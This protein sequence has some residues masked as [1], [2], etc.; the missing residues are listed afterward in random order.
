MG[1]I[2]IN[3]KDSIDDD[4]YYD[5][6]DDVM[7]DEE[8][9]DIETEYYEDIEIPDDYSWSGFMETELSNQR[10]S[11]WN[12]NDIFDDSYQNS[13]SEEE[14]FLDPEELGFNILDVK[15]TSSEII[16]RFL[17]LQRPHMNKKM[18]ECM[19]I[20]DFLKIFINN[21][22]RVPE[23]VLYNQDEENQGFSIDESIF[24]ERDTSDIKLMKRSYN[25]IQVL[26][27]SNLST[28]VTEKAKVIGKELMNIF[29]PKSE[30]NFNHFKYIWNYL[31]D[32]TNGEIALLLTSEEYKE[33]PV[34]KMLRY[35]HEHAITSSLLSSI[36]LINSQTTLQMELFTKLQ[37][38]EFVETI[39]AML[40]MTDFP[41]T[42]TAASEFLIQ[43]IEEGSKTEDSDILLFAIQMD[44]SCLS[45]IIKHVSESTSVVQQDACTELLLAFLEK[46]IYTSDNMAS[47]SSSFVF[48]EKTPLKPLKQSIL[49]YLKYNIYELCFGLK[50]SKI[51]ENNL[52]E[53]EENN[54]NGKE[55]IK[56]KQFTAKKR[57]SF[58]TSRL[59][60]LKIII[61]TL[62]E[63]KKEEYE[64][65][66]Y[67]PWKSL[68]KWFFKYRTNN[69]YHAIF[70]QY[71]EYS[72]KSNYVKALKEIYSETNFINQLID[73]FNSPEYV[74]CRGFSIL[75]CNHIRYSVETNSCEYLKQLLNNNKKWEQF[76]PELRKAT[77][78]QIGDHQSFAL[79]GNT[80]PFPYTPKIT[81]HRPL[82]KLLKADKE[83]K[84]KDGVE[85]G[86]LYAALLGYSKPE[87][88]DFK[89]EEDKKKVCNTT[90]ENDSD[91]DEKTKVNNEEIINYIMN[92]N[93]CETYE[94]YVYIDKNSNLNEE[95]SGIKDT[96][97]TPQENEIKNNNTLN[98]NTNE[99]K[100]E[101]KLKGKI[102]EDISKSLK[103][104]EQNISNKE[105]LIHNEK[106]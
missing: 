102:T 68:V 18:I 5:E 1:Y 64:I 55:I 33:P 85:L 31:I 47:T 23:S 17:D 101:Y 48:S 53:N 100:F 90:L 103:L 79:I 32:I 71:F 26:C 22:T 39:L 105:N 77:K 19:Q 52:C 3:Y 69:I 25:A 94:N 14:D 6:N 29:H 56:P 75:I 97:T 81:N 43:I 104:S 38:I 40:D 88:F 67:I 21:I 44:P 62:K 15:G 41:I 63:L 49:Q 98:F 2:K 4:L 106:E 35:I 96:K 87:E 50:S 9:E 73:N 54:I 78:R 57:K 28:F 42:I 83:L 89:K 20:N 82:A 10:I 30:G 74:D 59:N 46:C 80:R 61:I 84:N 95:N 91:N 36:F 12:A 51:K 70:Y 11:I 13:N 93:H 72:L 45:N 92:T 58:S 16:N 27:S 37:E 34:F 24:R 7:Y 76:L 8:D 66:E 99:I 65:L 60:L 86:S